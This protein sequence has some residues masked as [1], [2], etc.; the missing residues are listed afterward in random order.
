M[1]FTKCIAPSAQCLQ[2]STTMSVI[3]HGHRLV[4]RE[5]N[6]LNSRPAWCLVTRPA[7]RRVF[8]SA[9][10][11]QSTTGGVRVSKLFTALLALGIG[12]TGLGLYEF[13]TSFTLWPEQVRGDLRAGIKARNQG[14]LSLSERYI[15]RAFQTALSLPYQ[16]FAPDPYLKL[17][18]IAS[19][20]SEVSSDRR[21][22]EALRIAWELGA[23]PSE[24]THPSPDAEKTPSPVAEGAPGWSSY[25]LSDEE[26]L[27]RVALAYK[28]GQLSSER[29]VDEEEKWLIW[30]VEEVLR[31]SG[32]GTKNADSDTNT[33]AH[34]NSGS[35]A[36]EE[37]D[38]PAWMSKTDLGAPLEA[39][40]A[41]Y[42]KKGRIEYAMPLYLQAISL[43]LPPKTH[44]VPVED[45]CRAAQLMNNLS[46]LIMRRPPT[47]EIRAQ[48]EA[49]A[50]QALGVIER[51]QAQAQPS[52]SRWFEWGQPADDGREVCEQALGVGALQFGELQRNV[53]RLRWCKGA[54]REECRA[55]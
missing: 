52:S 34:S 30:A 15:T 1:Y 18:G 12:A 5:V 8:S 35:S 37:L 47:P 45:R 49:W 27:R 11:P 54:I 25:T 3:R 36:L 41:L 16:T 17:S 9:A 44:N 28:L 7:A 10:P 19:L 48:A 43:L 13:Y 26:R 21:S 24:Q 4:R 31:L 2:K 32:L 51:A 6:H 20:L 53:I 33:K 50:R 38:P 14:D 46:E 23:G 22:R 40:G 42:A 29:D 39:L 55:M